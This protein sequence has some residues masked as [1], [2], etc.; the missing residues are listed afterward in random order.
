MTKTIA[1]MGDRMLTAILPKAKASACSNCQYAY[2]GCGGPFCY[3]Y[4][5]R[6]VS[7]QWRC[8]AMETQNCTQH[9][10]SYRSGCC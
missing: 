1:R 8:Y 5:S 6:Y 3:Y 9:P 4:Y 2:K 10:L 7:G